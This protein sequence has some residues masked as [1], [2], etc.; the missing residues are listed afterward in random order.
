MKIKYC[1]VF[2]L[3]SLLYFLP[4]VFVKSAEAALLK[5]DK[6]TVSVNANDTFTVDVI[7]DA[8]SSQISSTDAYV[9]YDANVVQ[10]QSV[11]ASAF[12]PTV[13]NQIT[14]GKVF[15]YGTVDDPAVFKTGSGTVATITFKALKDGTTTLTYDCVQDSGSSSKI[16]QNDLNATNIIVCSQNGT[17][18]VTVGSGTSGASSGGIQSSNPS[19]L[20]QTG[21]IENLNR[22]AIPG[23][24]LVILGGVL[25]LIL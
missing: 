21:V 2:V 17:V 18:S 7:V 10:A 24:V 20:P 22:L 23:A 16:I 3:I 5:F 13:T 12:F 4:V 9:L 8:G 6:T 15:I 19:S 1:L 14:S 25:K 11:T